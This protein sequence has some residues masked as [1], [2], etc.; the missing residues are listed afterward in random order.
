MLGLV[1]LMPS[2]G[3]EIVM[4]EIEKS[5]IRAFIGISN[6]MSCH[7]FNIL[8][9][10]LSRQVFS[11]VLVENVFLELFSLLTKHF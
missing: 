1:S 4:V 7:R 9:V 8:S 3:D 2:L 11:D 5:V 6:M 10:F